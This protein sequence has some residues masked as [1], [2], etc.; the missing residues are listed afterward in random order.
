[1]SSYASFRGGLSWFLISGLTLVGLTSCTPTPSPA[2][3]SSPIVV[4]ATPTSSIQS[5]PSAS[6]TKMPAKEECL[7][8]VKSEL[9]K[10]VANFPGRAGIYVMDIDSDLKTGIAEDEV[11]ESASLM[12]L[13]VIAELYRQIQIGLH[14]LD[15]NLTLEE[16]QK[17]GGSGDLKEL[18]VGTALQ[19][20][21]V[22]TKMIAQSDNTATQM[23]TDLLGKNDINENAK[24]LGL[25]KTSIER[26]IYDFA[27]IEKGLDNLTTAKDTGTFLSLL[28]RQQLPGSAAIHST[29]EKQQRNDM[30]GKGFPKEI[31][32]AHKTGELNG[33]LHDAGIIYTPRGAVVL[34][35]LSDQ[36]TDKKLANKAWA[37]LALR[38][39]EIYTRDEEQGSLSDTPS[40]SPTPA[41]G[42]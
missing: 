23:L 12:K 8:L 42:A 20:K 6:P 7:R 34:V 40:P 16:G 31:R 4:S 17:V 25:L 18:K 39:V 38:V 14:T 19:L 21:T 29:L 1:M 13:I 32:Y 24:K 41:K 9:D 22:A 15:E 36:V 37:D 30:I 2:P 3:T 26:D 35:M 33:I 11:F 10:T 28:A 5:T 27:A